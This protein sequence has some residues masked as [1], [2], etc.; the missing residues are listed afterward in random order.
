MSGRTQRQRKLTEFGSQ[1]KKQVAESARKTDQRKQFQDSVKELSSMKIDT[2]SPVKLGGP[3]KSFVPSKPLPESSIIKQPTFTYPPESKDDD[4]EK[5][6]SSF[7]KLGGKTRRRK[8][9]KSKK[10][11]K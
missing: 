2:T 10:S 3:D 1:F 11:K 9:R 4:M 7:S 5:L 6:A 8:H